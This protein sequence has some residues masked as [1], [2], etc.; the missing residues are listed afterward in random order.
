MDIFDASPS[1]R[2]LAVRL[3]I[4][5]LSPQTLLQHIAFYR[6]VCML[7]FKGEALWFLRKYPEKLYIVNECPRGYFVIH[8]SKRLPIRHKDPQPARKYE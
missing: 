3:E 6:K 2:N 4:K 7:T 8:D 1:M 5:N